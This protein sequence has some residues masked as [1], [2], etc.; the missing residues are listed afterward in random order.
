MVPESGALMGSR[1]IP[2]LPPH[3]LRLPDG[4]ALRAAA[5][6]DAGARPTIPRG[7]DTREAGAG[8]S[9]VAEATAGL[10]RCTAQTVT[11]RGPRGRLCHHP[12]A[13]TADASPRGVTGRRRAIITRPTRRCLHVAD[14]EATPH[15]LDAVAMVTD[16]VIHLRRDP[17]GAIIEITSL[18]E[19]ILRCAAAIMV[20]T[21]AGAPALLLLIVRST[22]RRRTGSRLLGRPRPRREAAQKSAGTASP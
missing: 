21:M 11:A 9:T 20:G 19:A 4:E 18:R 17:L 14:L 10:G 12:A 3:S 16:T 1:S 15:H 2:P 22:R 6:P 13:A 7:S 5:H 8:S